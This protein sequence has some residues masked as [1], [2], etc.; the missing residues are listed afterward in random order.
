MPPARTFDLSN[1]TNL[2]IGIFRAN[3]VQTRTNVRVS[4]DHTAFTVHISRAEN[5][6]ISEPGQ[7]LTTAQYCQLLSQGVLALDAAIDTLNGLDSQRPVQIHLETP[8][9]GS[10]NGGG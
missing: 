5:L 1:G 6:S 2:E 10:S 3:T 4:F 9:A 7:D 8:S